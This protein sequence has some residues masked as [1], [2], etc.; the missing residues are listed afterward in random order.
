MGLS[1]IVDPKM[2]MADSG[3]NLWSSSGS[4]LNVPQSL[5]GASENG[6]FGGNVG[7][8]SELNV[9]PLENINTEENLQYDANNAVY[10]NNSDDNSKIETMGGAG[11]Y[12]EEDELRVGEWNF[13][14]LMR[15][16]SFLPALDFH[17][18]D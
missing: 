5:K 8:D 17:V 15:D 9:P 13:D 4:Y 7:M 1:Y 11:N 16:V 3:I 2:P 18:I 12:W 10:S 14:E 6:I